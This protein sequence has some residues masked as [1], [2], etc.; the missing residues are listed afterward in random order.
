[1][2]LQWE[3]PYRGLYINIAQWC[4]Q[5]YLFSNLSYREMCDKDNQR[6]G[7]N[8][9]TKRYNDFFIERHPEIANKYFDL[10]FKKEVQEY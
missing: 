3:S 2:L 8:S 5:P 7:G 4:N 1:M 6:K 9:A 10:H